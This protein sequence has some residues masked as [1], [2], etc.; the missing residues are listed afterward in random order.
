MSERMASGQ[1]NES[2]T[3]GP[4]RRVGIDVGGTFTDL[5]LVD[6]ATGAFHVG[7]TL[8]TSDDPSAAVE[9]GLVDLLQR[10]S[11]A[12][13]DLRNVIHG[14]TLV[15][16]AIIERKGAPTAL[17]TTRGFRD[18]L[19]IAREHR[20]DMHDLLLELP[21]PL[22]PREWRFE[23]DERVLADGSV[24]RALDPYQFDQI[25]EELLE[26]GVEAVAVVL[27]HGF[28]HSAHERV[29]R[30]R[31]AARAPALRVSLSSE[32]APEIREYERTTT[33]TANVY[34]Q[35]LMEGYLGRLETRLRDL[36]FRDRLLIMLS[37]GGLCTAETAQRFPV[38]IVESGPAA[39]ALAAG[40][41]GRQIGRPNLLSFDMG[42]TTAKACL[43]EAGHPFTTSEFEVDRKYR[44]KPGSGIPIRAPA[45]E[46]IEIGAG[47]GSI[48]R[49][50]AFGLVKVGPDS[51]GASPGPACYARGGT[52][53]TVTDADLI[54]GYLDPEFF[55]G[56]RISLDRSAAERAIGEQVARP[57]GLDVTAAAWAIHRVV[58][59]SMA[60]AA[61]IHAVERG[62]DVRQYPLF[63]FGGAGPVHAVHVAGILRVPEVIVP[64][65]AGVGSTLGFLVAPLAFDFV[66]GSAGRID[67]LDWPIVDDLY[68]EMESEGRAMLIAAGVPPEQ[69]TCERSCDMRLVGQAHQILVP[70]PGGHLTAD[71]AATVLANFERTYL[72]L[73]K[74]AAPGVPAEALNWR[75]QVRGP[76]PT[77]RL[78]SPDSAS[79]K[80]APPDRARK[81]ERPV[82][83]AETGFVATPVYDRY[84][85]RPGDAIAG[86]AIV[87]ERESTLVVNPASRFH[88]DDYLN[89]I[90]DMSSKSA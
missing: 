87:E 22:V 25:A 10:A 51:A 85:L 5:L 19:D 17:I 16:N 88:I 23:V 65:A 45:I 21:V 20:Y 29:V 4:S 27:I 43:I 8:T 52:Q 50:D 26:L 15:T 79:T 59:E 57:L 42:G 24:E 75:V 36:G 14:T 69:I 78:P 64:F 3:R 81:G 82:Y 11:I 74:R 83:F 38:R 28:R 46:M 77:L 53:P 62:K 41:V 9:A 37:N 89:V 18:V 67:R 12:A 68:E 61:R 66:R 63:A 71:S 2:E 1:S 33:T 73:F 54:L 84:A 40:Y 86:P 31:L 56:G 47:G 55:L 72:S 80:D 90:V 35:A 60:S 34:V 49:V 7:K 30:E 58:N 13:A 6:E 32:V 39:G 48:A 76:A 44:F 70:I